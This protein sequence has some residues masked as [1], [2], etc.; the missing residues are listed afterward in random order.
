MREVDDSLIKKFR[1]ITKMT[2]KTNEMKG[3]GLPN[4]SA[5]ANSTKFMGREAYL[6]ELEDTMGSEVVKFPCDTTPQGIVCVK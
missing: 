4:T 6:K 2:D 5:I 1:Q 3:L